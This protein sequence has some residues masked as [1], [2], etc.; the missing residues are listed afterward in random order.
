[1]AAEVSAHETSH[2]TATARAHTPIVELE[3]PDGYILLQR[4]YTLETER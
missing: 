3:T 2:A 4:P 1:M